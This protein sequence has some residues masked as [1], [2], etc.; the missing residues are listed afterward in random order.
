MAVNGYDFELNG[1]GYQAAEDAEGNSYTIAGEPL[2]PPNAQVVQGA[3]GNQTFQMKPD[4][5]LWSLSDWS[6]GEGQQ[7]WNLQASN[8]WRTLDAVDP[9]T[10]PGT[11]TPGP[12]N[13]KTQLSGVGTF[14]KAVMLVAINDALYAFDTQAA[15][16]YTWNTGTTEWDAAQVITGPTDGTVAL[17]HDGDKIFWMTGDGGTP[18]LWSMDPG[19]TT[20]T[21]LA[22][23]VM[24]LGMSIAAQ[25][26]N[27][28]IGADVHTTP[29]ERAIYEVPK[30][31]G[32]PVEID[33]VSIKNISTVLV[34]MEGKVYAVTSD[35]FRTEIREIT[36][37]S[38]A[39]TGFGRQ[40][41]LLEGFGA[42]GAWQHSGILYMAGQ[43]GFAGRGQILYIE[44][45]G[46]YGSLPT[47]RRTEAPDADFMGTGRS[48]NGNSRLIEHYFVTAKR[49]TVADSPSLW[50]VDAVSGGYANYS[51][52]D[53]D[54]VAYNV[55]RSLQVFKDE[56][57]YCG[58]DTAG[59]LGRTF[60]AA[61]GEFMVL[62]EAV[63]PWHNFGLADEKML[64]SIALSVEALPADWTVEVQYHV[65]GGSAA[66]ISAFS[67]TTTDGKGTKVAISTDTT[68]RKFHTLSIKVK[69]TYT[70]GGV[71]TSAP[72]ILGV[73]VYAQVVRLQKV[74]QLLIDLSDDKSGNQGWTGARK[75]ANIIAAAATEDV[76]DFKDGYTDQTPG[77]F[78]TLDVTIDTY[79][80]VMSTPG[81]GVAAVVLKEVV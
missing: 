49:S 23:T 46:T 11:L 81:E 71:P 8:A 61:E 50:V 5:L 17:C 39:G 18:T 43:Y 63:S 68:T 25:G 42:H 57:F 27:I 30:S 45:R 2:R 72:V 12:Y 53:S 54:M 55:V 33:S 79:N 37:T 51:Y 67:Y 44:P 62:S 29:A 36:P 28:Y 32:T 41:A 7:I 14:G 73:D 80:I 76:L 69:M 78:D 31:G 56:V 48:V 6:G 34:P 65:D 64:A 59:T 35:R 15:T 22:N 77:V 58:V 47:V 38:A 74:Y 1:V 70:G 4:T 24:G 10:R 21:Q 40:F 13:E 52:P 9:F 26:N 16:Y 75:R 19:D 60:R 3:G 66:W 20:A